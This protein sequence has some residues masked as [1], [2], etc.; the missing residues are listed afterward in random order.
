[1]TTNPNTESLIAELHHLAEQCTILLKE[2]CTLT[3]ALAAM[4]TERDEAVDI[5]RLLS[6]D[7]NERGQVLEAERA[8][9]A[10][11]ESE[12]ARMREASEEQHGHLLIKLAQIERMQKVLTSIACGQ[13]PWG[14]MITAA[15]NVIYS[16][17]PTQGE[18]TAIIA[19]DGGDEK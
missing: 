6:R 15:R 11:A 4:T 17:P 14:Q 1:M 2:N 18:T 16:S 9:R 3:A 13:I 12:L 19:T 5:H 10:T 8:K 7:H